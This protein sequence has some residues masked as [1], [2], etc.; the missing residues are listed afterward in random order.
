MQELENR[1]VRLIGDCLLTSA[2]LSYTGSFT[3]DYRKAM[4]YELWISDVREKALPLSSP[5]HLEDLL[6][7]EVELTGW[8]SEGLPSDELSVQNGILTMRASRCELLH[9]SVKSSPQT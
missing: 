9:A 8:A 5:F 4:V 2:F 7:N 1:K 6:T 3:F